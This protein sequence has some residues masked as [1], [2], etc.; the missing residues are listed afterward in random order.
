MTTPGIPPRTAAKLTEQT[1]VAHLSGRK[2]GLIL[3]PTNRRALKALFGDDVCAC[4]G[5]WVVLEAVPMRVAG[6][7]RLPIRIG[8]AQQPDSQAKE[9]QVIAPAKLEPDKPQAPDGFTGDVVEE[10]SRQ[11]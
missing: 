1:P 8:P 11:S 2:K 9:T 4:K 7:D 3:S 6:R 10:A 5:K